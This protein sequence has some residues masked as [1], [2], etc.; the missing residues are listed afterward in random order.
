MYA[1]KRALYV[2]IAAVIFGLLGFA[3]Q[4]AS[5]DVQSSSFQQSANLQPMPGVQ[6]DSEKVRQV[7]YE[8]KQNGMTQV[9]LNPIYIQDDVRSTEMYRRSDSPTD[10]QLAKAITNARSFGLK[11]VLKPHLELKNNEWRAHIAFKNDTDANKWQANWNA[12][13]VKLAQMKGVDT[14]VIGTE[15]R[16]VVT[17][18]VPSKNLTFLKNNPDR[19]IKTVALLRKKAPKVKLTYAAHTNDESEYLSTSFVKKLDYLSLTYYPRPPAGFKVPEVKDAYS[20]T[21]QE[22]A[23]NKAAVKILRDDMKKDKAKYF[24]PLRSKYGKNIVFAES[25]FRSIKLASYYKDGDEVGP[26]DVDLNFQNIQYEAFFQF[27]DSI[28]YVKGVWVYRYYNS[29]T[30]G[31]TQDPWFTPQNKPAQATIAKWFGGKLH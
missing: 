21:T 29:T 8:M 13:L 28:S 14:V 4:S 27:V 18:S 23:A 10:T 24:A 20:L 3:P 12:Q 30:M 17:K 9:V 22:R 25:G 31:G 26:K 11:I 15:M 6:L 5:A 1:F 16:G 7:F 2:L 19:W